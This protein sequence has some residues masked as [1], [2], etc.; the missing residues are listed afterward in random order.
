MKRLLQLTMIFFAL[1]AAPVVYAEGKIVYINPQVAMAQSEF[2]QAKIKE[3]NEEP[4]I[5]ENMQE[6]EALNEKVKT[7]SEQFKK[8]QAIMSAEQKAEQNNRLQSLGSDREHIIR[9]LTGAQREFENQLFRVMQGKINQ[10]VQELI[11]EEGIG[12][13]I[14]Q[15]VNYADTSYDYTAKVT[16]RLNKMK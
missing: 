3:F 4:S 14:T 15:G 6:L 1:A 13:V 11:K 2:G 7:L 16:E 9:K 5:K 10:A 12:M 8:D